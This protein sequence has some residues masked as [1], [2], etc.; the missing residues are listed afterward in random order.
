M[1]NESAVT[2]QVWDAGISSAGVQR[3]WKRKAKSGH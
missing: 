2:K 1:A 3:F